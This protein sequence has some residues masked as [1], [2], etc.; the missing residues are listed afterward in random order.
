MLPEEIA[1]IMID[2]EVLY[3]ALNVNSPK[4]S[5]LVDNFTEK[6]PL[7]S[8]KESLISLLTKDD[9]N[10]RFIAKLVYTEIHKIKLI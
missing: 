3:E 8:S 6:Y 10:I 1:E 9:V 5:E 2:L 7:T 4:V